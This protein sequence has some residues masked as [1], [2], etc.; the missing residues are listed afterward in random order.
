MLSLTETRLGYGL[1]LER[2]V[3][4]VCQG[5]GVVLRWYWCCD[6]GDTIKKLALV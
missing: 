6:T 2:R 4:A 5:V 1:L 3:C